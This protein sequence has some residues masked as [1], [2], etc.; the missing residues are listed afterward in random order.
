MFLRMIEVAITLE[1]GRRF[2]IKKLSNIS[3]M[4]PYKKRVAVLDHGI[5]SLRQKRYK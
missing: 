1:F 2:T 4:W 3:F 5:L